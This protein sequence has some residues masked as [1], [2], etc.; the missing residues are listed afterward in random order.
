MSYVA[1]L[2]DS[3]WPIVYARFQGVASIDG[4]RKYEVWLEA[5]CQRARSETTRIVVINDACGV[6]R[7]DTEVRKHI[8]DWTETHSK[9]N[10]AFLACSI[11]VLESRLMRGVMTAIAW[12]S[13]SKMMDGVETVGTLDAAWERALA[14]V[15]GE[16][17][18]APSTP[19]W[20]RRQTGT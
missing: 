2:D 1:E 8:S 4:Y 20:L 7:V 17:L 16:G 10:D 19:P 9:E 6:E 13:G 3:S 11:V 12:L 14:I 18:V 5:C 15:Q